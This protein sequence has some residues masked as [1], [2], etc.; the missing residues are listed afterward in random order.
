MHVLD[1]G[2]KENPVE[3]ICGRSRENMQTP[4]RMESNPGGKSMLL[5]RGCSANQSTTLFVSMQINIVKNRGKAELT[6][7]AGEHLKLFKSRS[8]LLRGNTIAQ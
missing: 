7:I 2:R 4:H 6:T 1:G 8:D 5:L 3:N